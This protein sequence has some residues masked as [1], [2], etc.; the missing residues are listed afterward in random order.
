MGFPFRYIEPLYRP[1]SEAHSLILPLTDGCSWNRCA[2]CEMYAAPQKRFRT[3]DASE[4]LA[5]IQALGAHAGAADIRRVFLADG[6]ALVLSTRRLLDALLA[7]RARLPAVR[8]VSCYGMPRNVR[9][10]S[11]Q[12][13]RELAAAGLSLVYVGAESGD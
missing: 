6:D 3:R 10:K 9:T 13:L 4:V 1:P 5:G 8:R 7:I 2:F 11:V 12:E